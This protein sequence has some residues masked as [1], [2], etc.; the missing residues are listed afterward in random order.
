MKKHNLNHASLGA[1]FG[2]ATG[3]ILGGGAY[4]LISLLF[5]EYLVNVQGLNAGLAGVVIMLGK[6]WD[7][8]TDPMMGII[9]DR[10]RSRAGRRRIYLLIG[11]L[12]VIFTFAM[13]WFDLGAAG[14]M[15]KL[16]YFSAAYMLF[17]TA[18]TIVMVPYNAL[19]PDMVESYRERAGFSTVRMLVSNLSALVTAVLPGLMLGDRSPAAYL[20]IGVLFGC[21]YGLPLIVTYFTTWELP[22]ADSEIPGMG[23]MLRQLKDSFRNRAYRQYLGIFVCGQMAT[24][25]TTTLAVFWLRDILGRSS[26][27]SALSGLTMIVALALLPLNNW[28]AQ[29]RGKQVPAIWEQPVRILG[30][31]IAFAM[32]KSS[33]LWLL[34]GVAILSGVGASA[35][36]FVPWT[37]LPDLPDSDEMISGRRNAGIYAGVSTFVRKFTSGVAIFLVGVALNAFGYVESSAGQ[38]AVQSAQALLGVRVLYTLVPIALTVITWVLAARFTMTMENH[39]KIREAV[40]IRRETGAP[41]QDPALIA[42][43]EQVAGRKF[44]TMWVGRV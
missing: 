3:D 34:L 18:F 9:S 23:E 5:L 7:A 26:M 29:H 28:L 36:T 22:Q 6:I 25:V 40:R 37:L 30:L 4:V 44:D 19:L 2:Y 38:S 24:D 8:V 27:L 13:M 41:A 14:Q 33:P 17:S 11:V 21:F 43:C 32:G 39:A 20:R 15:A 12:P 42:A 1:K 35:S 10:T 31:A 16:V